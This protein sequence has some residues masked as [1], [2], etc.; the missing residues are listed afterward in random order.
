MQTTPACLPVT[1][2]P[3]SLTL[4]TILMS[5]IAGK[6]H[7]L[8]KAACTESRLLSLRSCAARRFVGR[9]VKQTAQQERLQMLPTCHQPTIH[10]TFLYTQSCQHRRHNKRDGPCRQARLSLNHLLCLRKHAKQ[11]AQHWRLHM[12]P[13]SHNTEPYAALLCILS[14]ANQTAAQGGLPPG[15]H[16][17]PIQCSPLCLQ[18]H[19]AEGTTSETAHVTRR[20][21]HS[22]ISYFIF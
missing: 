7:C 1:K 4:C 10:C 20:F 19:Q 17:P 9:H 21:Y 16:P 13:T 3:T 14:H 6:S 8:L 5:F 18:A 11:K 2:S 15:S 12:S 22:T